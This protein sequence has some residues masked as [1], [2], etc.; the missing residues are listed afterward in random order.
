MRLLEDF[1]VL[2]FGRFIA[3][4]YC[5]ALLGDYGADVISAVM[6]A[7]CADQTR[8]EVLA[9]LA[10]ARIPAGPVYSPQEAL[11]DAH[12]QACGMLQPCHF[13]GMAQPF[14]LAQHPIDRSDTPAGVYRPAPL[15]GEHTD[16]ILASL[17][18]D[19]QAVAGLRKRGVV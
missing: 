1:R 6:S 4:P 17:G 13:P 14:P 16:E 2:D 12:I 11:E 5:A 3:G 8:D 9:A 18:Y 7:W 10:G 15:L 19:P